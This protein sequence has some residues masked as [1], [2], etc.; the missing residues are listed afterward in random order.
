MDEHRYRV[1]G[2]R[3]PVAPLTIDR[4]LVETATWEVDRDTRTCPSPQCSLTLS[5]FREF[6][7]NVRNRHCKVTLVCTDHP[8]CK[9]DKC[10]IYVMGPRVKASH[11]RSDA[12]RSGQMML[13]YRTE[14]STHQTER[15]QPLVLMGQTIERVDEFNYLGRL[16]RDDNVD[17]AAAETNIR[18]ARARWGRIRNIL[19]RNGA[20]RA[21]M[22]RFYREL[23]PSILLYGAE[24]WTITVKMVRRL[25]GFQNRIVR[26]I[27]Q[28]HIRLAGEDG[29]WIY[30]TWM[31]Y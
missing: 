1:H 10:G 28:E 3:Q 30:P 4:G 26:H 31:I 8:I 7:E 18:R 22:V 12:C 9:C 24:T 13:R 29:E 2:V 5:T 27:L 14:W 6:R 20:N 25:E 15:T 16:M 23:V 19:V 17:W 11:Y 21:I